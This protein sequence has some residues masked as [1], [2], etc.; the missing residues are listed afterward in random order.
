MDDS[1]RNL[2]ASAIVN[3]AAQSSPDIHGSFCAQRGGSAPRFMLDEEG[4]HVLTETDLGVGVV[5]GALFA[6][7][8]TV[9]A[10]D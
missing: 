3:S 8:M 1:G 10:L 4:T 9:G 5:R 6:E 2:R 7:E